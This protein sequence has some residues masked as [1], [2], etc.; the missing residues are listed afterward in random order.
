MRHSLAAHNPHT[1]SFSGLLVL[2]T[3]LANSTYPVGQVSG[4]Q[5]QA[6]ELGLWTL[7]KLV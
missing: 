3:K 2:E 7:R 1:E 4:I 6:R 5:G